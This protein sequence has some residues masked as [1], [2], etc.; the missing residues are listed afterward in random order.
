[1]TRKE[2]FDT[3]SVED[4]HF[5]QLYSLIPSTEEGRPEGQIN[6]AEITVETT[7]GTLVVTA[8]DGD[9]ILRRQE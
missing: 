5:S 3:L 7:R 4:G 8:Q 9:V 6:A 2:P 1:M